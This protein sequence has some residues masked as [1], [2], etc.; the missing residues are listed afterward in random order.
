MSLASLHVEGLRCLA[1]ADL[2]LAPHLNVI[3]GPNGSG[4]TSL[5]EAIFLAG[6]GRSFRTRRTEQLISRRADHLLVFAQTESPFHRIGFE[7]RR[8]ESYTAR[9]DGQDVQTLAQLPTAFFVEVIDPDVH[10]LIEGGPGERRRWLDWGVFHVEHSFLDHWVR[11]TRALRQRNAALKL[12][13]DPRIWDGELVT[14]GMEVSALRS[15]W[16]DSVRPFWEKAV[17]RLCGLPVDMAHFRGWAADRELA[18]VL[19]ANLE[20]DR[21]RGTTQSGPHRADIVLR[22]GGK[23]ARETLSRGQ[24]KLVAAS[25]VLALL[26]RLRSSQLT[27][28][29]LLLDDPAAELDR[30][31]LGHL[32]DLVKE[33]DCQIV[34]TSLDPEP[35]LF[36]LPERVFHVEQGRVQGL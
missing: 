31:R 21:E 11:Y 7:Y 35:R 15:A 12:G 20:K 23:A 4:K 6:R 24:Q 3:V 18:E 28:P 19:A 10:R 25:M 29:T 26:Q 36:G 16:F 27:P 9:L 32:V 33:L 8:N 2:A 22:I 34:M 1:S 17:E 5:L 13:Q 30:E 14:Q